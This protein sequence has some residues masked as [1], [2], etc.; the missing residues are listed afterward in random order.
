MDYTVL[1]PYLLQYP[2]L[3]PSYRIFSYSQRIELPELDEDIGHTLVHYL[4]AGTYQTLKP[5]DISGNIDMTTEYRRSI[6]IYCA[7]RTYGLNGLVSHA[8]GNM[9]SFD[10]ELSIFDILGLAREIYS[11]LPADE[12]WFPD[13]LKRRSRLHSRW[14]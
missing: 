7:A 11:K 1:R 4:Y 6:L 2:K 9:G 8:K 12:I 14:M 3:A 5:R 10:K 13:Y